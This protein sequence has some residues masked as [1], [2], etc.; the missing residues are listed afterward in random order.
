MNEE[1]KISYY[2]I[3]PANV[4]YDNRLKATE[5]LLYGE[6]T[7]LCNKSGYCYAKNRYFANL[8]EVSIETV[9]RWLSNLQKYNYIKIEIIRNLN[10]EIIARHIYIVSTP[11]PQK[12]QYPYIQKNQGTIDENIKDNIINNNIDDLFILIINNNKEIPAEFYKVLEKLEFI[13]TEEYIPRLQKDKLKM[14]KEIIY[15]LYKIYNSEFAKILS[16][17]K[18]EEL[19]NLYIISKEYKTKDFLNYYK[20]TVVNKYIK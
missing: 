12:N 18:R 8:Y 9:S 7:A 20:R 11:Y 14:L 4:R 5:K 15:T 1:N 6:I 17:A 2:A 3:I 13:Y 19:I 16:K 10:K